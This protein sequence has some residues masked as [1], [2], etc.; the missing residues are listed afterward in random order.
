MTEPNSDLS[1][2]S[3]DVPIRIDNARNPN[4]LTDYPV[5]VVLTPDNFD[6]DQA[7][8]DGA[9]LRFLEGDALLCHW[10]ER[11][12]PEAGEAVVWVRLARIPGAGELTVRMLYGNPEAESTSDGCATFDFFEDALGDAEAKWA[13]AAG[14]PELEYVDAAPLFEAPG[15]IWHVS[16]AKTRLSPTATTV[17]GGPHATY[18][19][20]TRPMAVYGPEVDKTFFAFG[21]RENAPVVCFYDHAERRFAPAVRVGSNP[22]MD[23]HR[24]PHLVIDEEGLLYIFYG[25]HCTDTVAVRSARPYDI[26]AWVDLGLV[27]SRSSY[28]QPWQV[29]E[30]EII[31]LY[32]GGGTHDATEAIVRSTDGGATWG[33][34]SHFIATPPKNGCYGVSVA[35]AGPFP[36]RLHFVW[37]VTRGDWWQRYHVYYAW[38]DDGGETWKRTDGEPYDV[39]ITEETSDIIFESDVPDRGVWLKDIQVAPDGSPCALFV[40][41]HTLNYECA[42]RFGRLRD[43]QWR[44]SQIATSDHMYDCGALVL[45]A[46]D[47]F[48]L[49]G[50]TTVSQPY[51]D[52]GEIEEWRS[53][54][55]GETWENTRHLTS[56]SAHSHNH[57]KAVHGG[58]RDDFRVFWCYGDARIPPDT[59]DVDLFRFG[60]ALDAPERMDLRYAARDVVS[61]RILRIEASEE[62]DTIVALREVEAGDAV[63]EGSVRLGIERPRHYALAAEGVGRYF[64]AELPFGF[65]EVGPDGEWLDLGDGSVTRDPARWRRW[66]YRRLG[67]RREFQLDDEVV[68]ETEAAGAAGPTRYALRVGRCPLH[69]RDLRV[70]KLSEPEPRAV[71]GDG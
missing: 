4:P 48:R 38:S 37:S 15:G 45:L 36:R 68:A 42:W 16:G 69:A 25:S 17:Y 66:S 47:D 29:R 64:G 58:G 19:A 44:F 70:R 39:P 13:P 7:R 35:A 9:D 59:T 12:D 53:T 65:G 51:E 30:D 14:E 22:N 46:E 52:G 11:Y 43:G 33:E 1:T 18:C 26:E 56:G 67:A 28:P 6:F 3:R 24:N 27:A 31:V 5:R 34:P 2:W 63:L 32:R 40:D 71:I 41:G 57:V 8:A 10:T 62:A 55:G 61:G 49:Y 20:W 23:A 60:E 21:N 50:P 54:D